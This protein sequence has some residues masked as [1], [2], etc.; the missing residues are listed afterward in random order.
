MEVTLK[1][2][3]LPYWKYRKGGH[4]FTFKWVKR[5]KKSRN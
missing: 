5:R 2:D 4:L 3:W 1:R